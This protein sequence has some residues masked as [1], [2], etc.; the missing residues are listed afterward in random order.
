M[1]FLLSFPQI[2][3]YHILSDKED[4]IKV[5]L[6]NQVTLNIAPKVNNKQK[7]RSDKDTHGQIRGEILSQPGP[8]NFALLGWSS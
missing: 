6:G 1:K 7:Y 2:L 3:S 8:V 4:E 5:I